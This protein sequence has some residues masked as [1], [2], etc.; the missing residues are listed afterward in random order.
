MELLTS[1]VILAPHGFPTREGGVSQGAFRSLNA[2]FSVGDRPEDV[3]ENVRRVAVAAGV[4][5]GA[6]F[7][8]T[9]THSTRVIE[10]R[11]ARGGDPTQPAAEADAI[12]TQKKGTAVAVKTA[13]CVPILIEDRA[14]GWVAAVHAGWRGVLGDI[15]SHT[16]WAMQRAGTRL[17]DVAVAIGPCIQRCCFEVGDE[18]VSR[19]G[20]AFGS[21]VVSLRDGDKR[22]LDLPLALHI[23]LRRLGV[24]MERIDV[25]PACT[26]CDL[27][28]FSHRREK[29]HTGRHLSFITC[30]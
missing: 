24:P 20:A 2:A 23:A 12:W 22:H 21:E 10:A 19:F 15:A 6:L 25:L 14:K 17:D 28:F 3:A 26:K 8:L 11:G 27:R 30:A 13:D 5:P 4:A 9:Q 16:L 18:L 29:G 7:T 1:H